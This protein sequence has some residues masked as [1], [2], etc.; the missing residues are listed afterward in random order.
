MGYALM[1][2]P[3]VASPKRAL[4]LASDAS[5]RVGG[6]EPRLS[7]SAATPLGSVPSASPSVSAVSA[8]LRSSSASARGSDIVPSARPSPATALLSPASAML[9]EQLEAPEEADEFGRLP[10]P[11]LSQLDQLDAMLSEHQAELRRRVERVREDKTRQ[12]AEWLE[13][14]QGCL[15]TPQRATPAGRSQSGRGPTSASASASL[16][17]SM[18]GSGFG[19]ARA[20]P[21]RA[22]GSPRRAP[23]SPGR[24]PPA[25][26]AAEPPSPLPSATPPRA[27]YGAGRQGPKARSSL[28]ARLGGLSLSS[29]SLPCGS[30]RA[31]ER[32]DERSAPPSRVSTDGGCDS[33]RSSLESL[34]ELEALLE[35]QHA[36]LISKGFIPP[37]QTWRNPGPDVSRLVDAV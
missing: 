11:S 30:G 7:S 36:Q 26:Q 31:A 14:I 16:T 35:Q 15:P 22:P 12:H 5:G 37:E 25:R 19:S 20:S 34:A 13:E 23:G 3:S 18:P 28:E 33:A 32:A 1:A 29:T 27:S 2:A 4:R 17:G 6:A 10:E 9:S 8:S 21:G 24:A